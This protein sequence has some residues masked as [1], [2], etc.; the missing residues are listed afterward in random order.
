VH[1]VWNE[2]AGLMGGLKPKVGRPPH[3]AEPGTYT[4]LTIRIPAEVKNA[5]VDQADAY[6]LTITEYLVSLLERDIGQDSQ[7]S[8]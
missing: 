2:V 1:E 3:K 8:G 4:T 7:T 5:M 6:D